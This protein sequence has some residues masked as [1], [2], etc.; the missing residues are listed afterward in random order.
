MK[1][2]LIVDDQPEV[3]KLLEVVL[4]QPDREF[5]SA[6]SGVEALQL[7]RQQ[8]PDLILLDVMM[9]G[10]MDGYQVSRILKGDPSTAGCAIIA[11]TARVQEQD[12]IDAMAAGADDYVGKPFDMGTLKEKVARYLE[13]C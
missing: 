4:R 9:P 8:C 10:G 11:M 3:K 7:A 5:L 1:R 2:I 13:A 6:S 12:R